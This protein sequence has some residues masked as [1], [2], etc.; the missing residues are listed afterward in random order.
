M[1]RSRNNA[2]K[3]KG[4]DELENKENE[5]N[6][7]NIVKNK[8]KISQAKNKNKIYQALSLP[9]LCNMNPRSVYNKIDE[10]HEF[11]KEEEVDV[12][13]MSESW[14]R[15][16]LTLDQI[17][18]LED[19]VVISNVSQRA[20]KGGRPA[21][22]ANSK[23]YEVQ[24]VTNTLIQIPWGV[25][26]VWCI[27]TPRNVTKDS[28]IQKIACCSLYC[29]P[30]SR[31]KSLLLDHISDSFNILSTK[32]GRGLH[33]VIAGDTNDLNLDP[34]LNL[35]PNFR[36]I[37][38]DW[39]RMNPPALLDPILMT[40]SN[41]YQVPECLDPLDSDPDKNGKKSDHRIVLSKPINMI[42]NKSG[43]ETRKVQVRPFTHS[44]FEKMKKWFIDQSWEVI[45][46]VES[47]HEKAS[48]LQKMLLEKLDDFFPEKTRKLSSDDQP[49]ISHKIKVLDRKRKR[50]YRK[51]RR[52][53]KWKNMDKNF[54]N[55]VKNAKSDFY[56]KSVADLKRKNP[57]QW[58]SWLKRV[59]SYDQR[60]NQVNI[61]DINHLP[62]QEQA[63]IIA[64]KFSS[65]QNEYEPIKNE[66]VCVPPFSNEDVPQ[67]QP[68]QVWLLLTQLKTNKATVPGD[69]P[70][71]LIKQFAAYLAE[72]LTDIINAG[73]R[74]GEYPQVY[75]FEVCTPVPKSYPPQNTAQVRNISGLLTF[76]KIMEKLISELIIF[77]MSLSI[78]PAQYGN[79][80][81]VSI[82]H[83]LINMIHRI[84]TAVDNN[85]RRE[86][87][88]VIANLI[89][90]NNAFPRQC[91]KLGIESFIRNGVRPALI[92]VL[93]NYFQNREMSVKWHGCRSVPRKIHGGGPQ[94]AT[95][96]LL[97]YLS[98]SNNCADIVSESE[99]FKFIDD[100]SVL[101][102]VNLLTVGITSFNLKQQ[103]ASDIPLHN[104]FIPSQNLKS[105]EW[106]N[107]ISE[108]T[109]NQK[110]MI[111]GKKTKTLI[112]NYTDNYQF[113]TRL[114]IDDEQIDVIDSTRLLG[115]IIT[116]DLKW[117]SNCANIVKKANARM[118]LL[119]KVAS[120]GLDEEELKN[121]YF[122][123]IRSVLEQS[124]TV[125]HS[126]LTEDN[127]SDL[128]RV[129]K[130]AVRIILGEKYKGYRNALI[131][132]EIETLDERREL[133][134]KFAR[135][136]TKNHDTVV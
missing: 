13:F 97:E 69:F 51:E 6:K 105:Q 115:T 122:L 21:L 41:F 84:L 90:W 78:D 19:H 106:L 98:Q 66:D 8:K 118:Q 31:K 93:I 101:E 117:D 9:V 92:P 58:Y 5:P 53:E 61:E 72:P 125:W 56:K 4:N 102:I 129:Q 22:I 89:D 52:S 36:Q 83:Y 100:L 62:D 24:N 76:D 112:F 108:W 116:N 111:N 49:W 35:T 14:E 123:F 16:N 68:S 40:L 42:N 80:K 110:M 109:Q 1:L 88:A 28:K 55:E 44:G 17:I 136:T 91:P 54:K 132:L 103:V 50:I 87:F 130:S 120:F 77:D 95:I 12:L 74:R 37:V 2:K 59:S 126:S 119:R 43:R 64:D 133:C 81:G 134:L 23:K 45:F 104:Q 32:Y 124:A 29:K 75:K 121:I 38:R 39:T 27:L 94:G 65:I 96:G 18:N 20:G 3:N 25:E 79:Q 33:F 131:K 11:M 34:I 30:N 135:K 99:R 85:S 73:I 7:V 82:Q 113:T 114:T 107:N 86:T 70:A 60:E 46:Q 67:F 47:A 127:K 26:A 10:F 57:G 48:I 15:K 128:E 63:E 71:K